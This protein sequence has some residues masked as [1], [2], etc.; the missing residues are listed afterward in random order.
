MNLKEDYE[1]IIKDHKLPSYEYLNKEFE[2][3]YVTKLEEIKFPLRF[4]RRRMN[5]KIAW[6]CNILQNIIQPNPGSII[7]LEESKFFS[8]EDKEKMICLLRELM[9]IERESLLLDIEYDNKKDVEYINNVF[10]KWDKIKEDISHFSEILK[11]GWKT[12]IKKESKEH[13]FG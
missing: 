4:I 1:K 2:L 12:D 8:N 3:M 9:Y 10:N 13:Y 5:D 6:F 7:G 11:N